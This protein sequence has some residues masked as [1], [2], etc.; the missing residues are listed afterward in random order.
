MKG[1]AIDWSHMTAAFPP[2]IDSDQRDT[3]QA[4]LL[5][6][7]V[8]QTGRLAAFRRRWF[9]R[10]I[11]G[12]R[13]SHTKVVFIRLP[14]GPIPRPDGLVQ[15]KSSSIREFAS[16]PNVLLCDEHAFDFLERPELFKD[17]VH[18]NRAGIAVFS[19]RLA[20]TLST[21]LTAAKR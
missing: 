9:G 3:V 8:P 18:L 10:I 21:L 14:R 6:G 11:E 5:H 16:R 12:Y 1:L 15:K 7:P 20:A 2:N 19:E 17:G 4:A 13:M